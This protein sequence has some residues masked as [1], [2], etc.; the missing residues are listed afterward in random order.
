[1]KLLF[2]DGNHD[3][4]TPAPAISAQNQ[5]AMI[6]MQK[7]EVLKEIE[8]KIME[9]YNQGYQD[10]VELY[11]LVDDD[12]LIPESELLRRMDAHQIRRQ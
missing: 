5:E 6:K 10:A 12:D 11:C 9:A 7:E 1:M 3:P 2:E 8:K 4:Q